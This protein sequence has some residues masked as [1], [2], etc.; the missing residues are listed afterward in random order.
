ML[1]GANG[2]GYL[3]VLLT[4]ILLLF[5]SVDWAFAHAGHDHAAAIVPAGRIVS[6]MDAEPSNPAELGSQL[7]DAELSDIQHNPIPPLHQGNCCCGS[8]ACH[9]GVAAPAMNVADPYRFGERLTLSPVRA[10]ARACQGGIERP[11]REH[12]SV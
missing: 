1:S 11:P 8:V 6:Y 12:G 9:S 3:A 5:G 2:R 10:P 7:S 4:G